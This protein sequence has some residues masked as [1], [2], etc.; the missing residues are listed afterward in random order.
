[1]SVSGSGY[2]ADSLLVAP[3]GEHSW[4]LDFES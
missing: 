2:P 4:L 1:M 3:V